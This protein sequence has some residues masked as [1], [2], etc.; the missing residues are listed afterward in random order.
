VEG[1]FYITYTTDGVDRDRL[2]SGTE[3]FEMAPAHQWQ[4]SA[5]YFAERILR[6]GRIEF[7]AENGLA[8]LKVLDAIRRSVRAGNVV[9]V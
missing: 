9:T 6:G 4:L 5:E 8:N 1:K 2:P 7:P 3:K